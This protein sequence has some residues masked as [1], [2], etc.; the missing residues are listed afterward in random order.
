MRDPRGRRVRA[1]HKWATLVC[2]VALGSA[3]A[4]SLLVGA[5]GA[6]QAGRSKGHP[7]LDAAMD[8]LVAAAALPEGDLP[9][10]ARSSSLR[11]EGDRV[12]VQVV[13]GEEGWAAAAQAIGSA[14]GEVTSVTRGKT[15]IQGWV[16][17]SALL[18]LAARPD[19][20]AILRPHQA[21]FLEGIEA[22]GT[23]TEAL[24]A[25]GAEA[26]HAAGFTGAGVRVAVIDAGFA[27]YEALLGIELPDAVIVRN[28]VDGETDAQ[29]GEG[30][31]HG[32]AC[33]EVVHDVAP[34]AALYLVKIET[35]ADLEQA[36]AW[37]RDVAQVDLISTSVGWYHLTPGDGTGFLADL[38]Q[39]A[40]DAGILWVTAAG[41]A[42]EAHWGGV[43]VDQDGNDYHDFAG[44]AS[45]PN[46][47]V[48]CFGPSPG[49][50]APIDAGRTLTVSVRW[51]DWA[52]VTQDYDLY[53]HR[54]SEATNSWDT[55][56]ASTQYQDGGPGQ[57]PTEWAAT[58]TTGTA[59]YYGFSIGRFVATRTVH[60]E[61]TALGLGQL[62]EVVHERSLANLA[63]ASAALAVAAV[64]AAAPHAQ[65]AYSSEG[66]TNGP[67]G[68]AQGGA[69]KPDLAGY[70]NVST[71][72]GGGVPLTGTGGA[73]A[74]VA[75]AAALLMELYPGHSPDAIQATLEEWALDLGAL[76]KDTVYGHGRLYLEA[77]PASA[78]QVTGIAPATAPNTSTVEI[79]ALTGSGFA[80]GATVRMRKVGAPELLATG[81]MVVDPATIQCTIDLRGAAGGWWDVLVTNPD[82]LGDALPRAFE[83]EAVSRAY[84]PIVTRQ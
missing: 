45:L 16:P 64:D 54:W 28:T 76:G 46:D 55:P 72:S 20:Y 4:R 83:V 6:A 29:V 82:G 56:G 38:A 7:K 66:P 43:Y 37:L 27:G 47:D 21:V 9:A 60:L 25:I 62:S 26:W 30:T 11:T 5:W 77:P 35:D 34:D 2:I 39:S 12:H 24:A 40:R 14:G 15:L 18:S 58:V 80:A 57:T 67:G 78:P 48:N 23:T 84:L 49:T 73:T 63:D 36:V 32:T 44:V 61:V 51:D 50:C 8:A 69:V 17:V 53:L 3:L 74:H 79:T 33:A 22:G 19:V 70:A 75:G 52:T 41:D 59:T 31:S 1:A 10:A 68:M 81:V 65:E 42:R 71:A 13:V